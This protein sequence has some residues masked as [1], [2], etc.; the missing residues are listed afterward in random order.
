MLPIE[1]YYALRSMVTFLVV[2]TVGGAGSIGGAL[3]ASLILGAV[4]ITARYFTPDYGEFF[5]FLA[6]IALVAVFPNG[7]LRR[8]A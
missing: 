1:P 7:L 8:A 2:V 5:F 3:L 6:V 4:E